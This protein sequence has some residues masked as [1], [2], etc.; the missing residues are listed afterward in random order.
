MLSGQK[1]LV[2][3]PAGQIAGPLCAFLA[4]QNEVWGIAR[5]SAPGSREEVER[6]GVTTRVV[7]LS[8]PDLSQVPDD[9]DYVLHLAAAIG[10][11]SDY[12]HSLR[13]NAEATGFVL[14]HCRKAKAALVM[15]TSSV[16]KPNANSRH[17]YLESDPLG[18]AVLPGMPTYSVTKIAEEAVARYCAR[19]LG[20]RVVIARMN[21][22]Y[23]AR[24]GLPAYHLDQVV[25]GQAV[26]VR[27]D[28]SPYSPI[29]QDDINSQL[30]A[31]LS[32][33]STPA[34]IVNW[35]GDDPI[36]PHEWCAVF[37]ELSGR[38]ADVRVRPV[39][40]SQPGT[41]LDNR[42]RLSI[43]GPCKVRFPEGL[44]RLYEARY[45]H[46]PSGGAEG[47]PNPRPAVPGA[48]GEP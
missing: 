41:S 32:A 17:L 31:L 11:G 47:K 36:G 25:T 9:F 34:T 46:G 40:G 26:F 18:E 14:S 13:V 45:P 30:E 12:D 42:K 24:G 23:S 6:M 16:Y 38:S 35:G 44:R 21:A 22:A 4:G 8:D 5:F 19:A 33:A 27:H 39:P 2:T 3:G 28:P 10:P 37:A 7:D 29:H 43:T 20:L 1:I 15:S 48:R